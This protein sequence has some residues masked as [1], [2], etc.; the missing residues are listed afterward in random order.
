MD[1][2]RIFVKN[3]TRFIRPHTVALLLALAAGIII[4][5]PQHLAPHAL[6]EAYNNI[7]FMYQDNEVVYLSRVREFQ[8]GNPD[9]SSPFLHEYKNG[10]ANIQPPVGELFYWVP[11]QVFGVPITKILVASKYVYP[12]ILFLIFY[13][14]MYRVLPSSVR[15]RKTTALAGAAVS[16]LGFEFVHITETLSI[17]TGSYREVYL[18]V[19]TRLVHPIS[20]ALLLFPFL[21]SIYSILKKRFLWAVPAA[22]LLGLSLGYIFAFGIGSVVLALLFVL[23]LFFREWRTASV[24]AAVGIGAIVINIPHLISVL[25]SVFGSEQDVALKNGLFL[26]HVPII[27]KVLVLALIISIAG[28]V[29][30]IR[31]NVR[32]TLHSPQLFFLVLLVAGFLAMNQHIVTGKTVW[33]QHFVQY[34][35]PLVYIAMVSWYALYI[36]PHLRGFASAALVLLIS[37]SF[38]FGIAALQTYMHALEDYTRVNKYAPTLAYLNEQKDECVVLA[39]EKSEHISNYITALTQCDVYTTEYTFVGVPEERITHNFFVYLR[40]QGI[41][42]ETVDLYIEENPELIWRVFYRDWQDY[43]RHSTDPWLTRIS[44]RGEIDQWIQD[45]RASVAVRYKEFY[46]Q[47]FQGEL[48]RYQLD[49]IVWDREGDTLLSSQEFPFL[50]EVYEAENVVIYRLIKK[51]ESE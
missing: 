24:L 2:I 14:L 44:D 40:F 23:A 18:S 34:T 31:R 47:D 21:F 42:S 5:L 51:P 8:D 46:K 26:T 16:T 50:E 27:S 32:L 9:V 41:T 33:P 17:L 13:A 35:I 28:L 19:W 22:L 39:V 6:G 12:A 15:L 43:F 49:Y 4:G 30:D 20:G 36:A 11:A 48:L 29:Y 7:P 25:P 1:Q 10:D 45:T 37:L 3:V 38:V